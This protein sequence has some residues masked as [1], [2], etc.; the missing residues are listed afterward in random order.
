MI[1]LLDGMA[2]FFA[3]MEDASH[4]ARSSARRLWSWTLD[5]PK[6]ATLIRV[7]WPFTIV[8]S[9]LLLYSESPWLSPAVVYG[10]VLLYLLSNSVLYFID[11]RFFDSFHF[12]GALLAFDTLFFTASLALSGRASADFYVVYFTTIFLCTICRDLR[13]L[14]GVAILSPLLYGYFLLPSA[15]IHE[16]T[17]YLRIVFPFVISLFY[18]YFVQVEHLQKKLHEQTDA[19]SHSSQLLE[20]AKAQTKEI[21]LLLEELEQKTRL[22]KQADRAREHFLGIMSH[23]LRTPLNVVMG[24][25]QLLKD[26]VLGEINPT[27]AEAAAKIM[28]HA[29]EQLAMVTDILEAA[30]IEA[31]ESVNRSEETQ[32]AGLLDELKSDYDVAEGKDVV[33]AWNYPAD[34]PLVK[35]DGAK[36]KHALRN[37]INNALKFTHRG[38]VTVSAQV[39]VSDSPE[40]GGSPQQA[41]KSW[42]EIRVA[43]TGIGI[44]QEHLPR[45]FDR[46]HQIDNSNTRSYGGV[47]MGLYVVGKLLQMLGAE[48]RVTSTPG[49][50][51]IFTL[52]L[53]YD[54]PGGSTRLVRRC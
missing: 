1:A 21:A 15:D 16:P 25:A 40:I 20:T 31:G 23:E 17:L 18:G 50:G 34:L 47:G 3:T 22:W 53:R 37:I 12:F 8:C 28:N 29:K 9:Y 4:D 52:T 24:Y 45:I 5:V 7:R 42:V 10:F 41:E 30:S 51:S 2:Q 32:L 6:K 11:E 33:L 13:G 39:V 35:I 48:I 54:K 14:I 44:A 49:Q 43:D 38:T 36:L 46:F 26:R 27:Q 19:V